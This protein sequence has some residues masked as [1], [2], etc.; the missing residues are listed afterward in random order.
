M[1]TVSDKKFKLKQNVQKPARSFFKKKVYLK[2]DVQVALME[3]SPL[4][5]ATTFFPQYHKK[6][7][8]WVTC[9][10][11]FFVPEILASSC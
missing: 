10:C 2:L 8:L 1:L 4:L 11:R 9:T 7:Q 5:D 6:V 3:L